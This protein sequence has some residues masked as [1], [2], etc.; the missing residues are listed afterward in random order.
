LCVSLISGNIYLWVLESA[1]WGRRADLA[2][3]TFVANDVDELLARLEGEGPNVSDEEISNVG[4]WADVDLL[5]AYLR[6]GNDINALS[7]GGKALISWPVAKGNLK[8]VKACVKRGAIL[9]NRGLLHVAI[10]NMEH[11]VLKFL[12]DQGLD[13][14]ELNASGQTPMDIALPSWTGPA[15]Q[16]LKKRG[17]IR[18]TNVN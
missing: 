5:D 8:F 16:L 17:G 13:P 12:L 18:S 14:N 11:D 10:F 15:V 1:Y 7:S 6:K 3:L 4:R 9:K 2:E